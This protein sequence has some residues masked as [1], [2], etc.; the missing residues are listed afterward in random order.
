MPRFRIGQAYLVM[1]YRNIDPDI[2]AVEYL[3]KGKFTYY[4]NVRNSSV[5]SVVTYSD[6]G[7]F[8]LEFIKMD[9]PI[10]IVQQITWNI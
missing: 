9:I 6:F 1:A 5:Y 8:K 3:G 4:S 10:E 2:F 7:P